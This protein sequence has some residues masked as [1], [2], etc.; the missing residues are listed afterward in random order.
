MASRNELMSYGNAKGDFVMSVEA[1][2]MGSW[3]NYEI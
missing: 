3:I 2:E 1:N